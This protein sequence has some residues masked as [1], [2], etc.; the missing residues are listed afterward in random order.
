M[1]NVIVITYTHL[2]YLVFFFHL[3]INKQNGSINL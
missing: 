3:H 1:Y 2:T